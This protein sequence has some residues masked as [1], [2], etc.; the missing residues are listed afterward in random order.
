MTNLI[1]LF[2]FHLCCILL[3]PTFPLNPSLKTF[4]PIYFKGCYF[5][6]PAC[7]LMYTVK[8]KQ[9]DGMAPSDEWCDGCGSAPVLWWIG[10][11]WIYKGFQL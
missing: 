3:V 6:I 5:H 1:C 8:M 7:F 4:L 10:L 11:V 2:Q 9:M